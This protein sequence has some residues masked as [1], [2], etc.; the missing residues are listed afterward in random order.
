MEMETKSLL[1]KFFTSWNQLLPEFMFAGEIRHSKNKSVNSTISRLNFKEIH[2][3][4]FYR[5]Y[6][7]KL[8]TLHFPTFLLFWCF[9]W[10][11][12]NWPDGDLNPRPFGLIFSI[13]AFTA[14]WI[15]LIYEGVVSMLGCRKIYTCFV[16]VR[17]ASGASKK[18]NSSYH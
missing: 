10:N 12:F 15:W 17:A 6:R 5:P 18:R 9:I 4:L 16:W 1:V 8:L 13:L 7:P 2:H 14:I 3:T 11:I